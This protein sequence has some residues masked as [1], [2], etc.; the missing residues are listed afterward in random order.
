MEEGPI[1]KYT[2]TKVFLDPPGLRGNLGE[3]IGAQSDLAARLR[4]TE[5]IPN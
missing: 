2:Y 3:A 1:Q 5:K 4:V